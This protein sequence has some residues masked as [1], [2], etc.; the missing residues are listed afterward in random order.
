MTKQSGVRFNCFSPPVML[1]TLIVEFVLAGYTIWRYKL[2]MV[3]R[4]VVGMLVSLAT[5]Q[6]A[7]YQVCTG[8][9]ISAE[10]WSR[11]GYVA[12]TL[13]PALG[14]HLMHVLARKPE[15]RYVYVAYGT[16]AAFVAYFMTYSAAFIGYK[17]TGNYVIFQIGVGPALAYGLYY[18]GWLAVSMALGMRWA[19]DLLA[20]GKKQTARLQAVRSLMIGYLIFLVPTALANSVNPETRQGIPSIMC[21]FAV[22]FALILAVYLMPRLGTERLIKTHK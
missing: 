13:L 21:G 9:G 16:M 5:F 18:Y 3:G 4:L 15:R 19:N 1:V 22:L 6:V 8:Y 12:I 14:F 20:A 7:E 11:L 17:C 10:Q 2:D